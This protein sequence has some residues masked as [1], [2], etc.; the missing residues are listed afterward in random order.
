MESEQLQVQSWDIKKV[1]PYPKNHKKHSDEQ[2]RKL[3]QSMEQFGITQP[4][5]I[6]PKGTIIAGEGRYLA[7]KKMGLK[8]IP[9]IVKDLPE[10]KE[11][12]Y[13]IA[14]NELATFGVVSDFNIKVE[15]M[16]DFNLDG[17]MLGLANLSSQDFAF[18]VGSTKSFGDGPARTDSAMAAQFAAAEAEFN[19]DAPA[20][21]AADADATDSEDSDDDG[22]LADWEE[23]AQPDRSSTAASGAA[24]GPKFG[25]YHFYVEIRGEYTK[26]ALKD[27]VTEALRD[28][29]AVVR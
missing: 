3:V 27:A 4:I 13:R 7:M 11:R 8:Q 6:N 5:I 9:V 12:V 26:A 18:A 1:K 23:P 17:E 21:P 2:I 29:Q 20:A 16:K 28:F 15:E 22:S 24:P 14:D 19:G 10:A 25:T